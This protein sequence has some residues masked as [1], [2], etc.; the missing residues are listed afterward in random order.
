M[1]TFNP[2]PQGVSINGQAYTLTA[3]YYPGYET[4]YDLVYKADFLGNFYPCQLTLDHGG[5]TATF[6]NTEAAFQATKWWFDPKIRAE[7]ENALTG[8]DA[9]KIKKKYRGSEDWTYGGYGSN[10]NAMRAILDVKFAQ[11]DF[12]QGL[13]DSANSYLLE[14]NEKQGRD[15][16]WSDDNNGFGQNHLGLMLMEIRAQL[17]GK[18]NLAVGIPVVDFT[19]NVKYH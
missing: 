1:T 12:K 3:F 7:F 13:L 18:A 11:S 14:H 19:N 17:G 10:L 4:T 6:H 9:F 15:N 2:K 8:A 5:V 16:F